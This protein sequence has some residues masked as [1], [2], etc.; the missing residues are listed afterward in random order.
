MNQKSTKKPK[1]RGYF[2]QEA[3]FVSLGAS[4][5]MLSL[6]SNV[7][8]F[9]SKFVFSFGLLFLFGVSAVYHRPHWEP[10]RRAFLRKFDHCAI[11][12]LI[13]CTFTPYCVLALPSEV[14][15]ELLILIW[16]AAALGIGQTFFWSRAPKWLKTIF[17]LITGWIAIFY[18]REFREALNFQE[19]ALT[20][21]GGLAYSIGAIFYAIRKPNFKANIFGYHELFHILTIVAAS[22]HFVVV[23]RLG[24]E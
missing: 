18:L 14:G 24:G 5:V 23:F 16:S 17:F 1:L 9:V 15:I 6:S 2:H 22:M 13:A 8:E 7:A 11:F 10:E 20:L 19:M 21:G 3:F 4:I 12:I